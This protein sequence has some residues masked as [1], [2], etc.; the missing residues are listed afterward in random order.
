MYYKERS[1]KDNLV[2]FGKVRINLMDK[3]SL[4][5]LLVE[6]ILK[7]NFMNF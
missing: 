3:M 2:R 6:Q 7:V 5:K 4:L 1:V